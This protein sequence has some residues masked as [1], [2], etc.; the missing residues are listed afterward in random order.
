MNRFYTLRCVRKL[1]L[2]LCTVCLLGSCAASSPQSSPDLLLTEPQ[3]E[4]LRVLVDDVLQVIIAKQE[5]MTELSRRDIEALFASRDD[6][7]VQSLNAEQQ[8]TYLNGYRTRLSVDVYD[9]M[10]AKL[11]RDRQA[12]ARLHYSGRLSSGSGKQTY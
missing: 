1:S 11:G 6:D 8:Q 12:D 9:T 2:M 10:H 7:F 3:S 5:G 4:L